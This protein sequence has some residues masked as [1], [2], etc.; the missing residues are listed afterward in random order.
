MVKLLLSRLVALASIFLF[1]LSPSTFLGLFPLFDLGSFPHPKYMYMCVPPKTLPESN[2]FAHIHACSRVY[3]NCP[4]PSERP[5][6][7]GALI[8]FSAWI[9]LGS[10]R[11]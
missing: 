10:L 4:L 1:C 11:A 3:S 2:L 7:L 8:S 5:A 9:S 6:M